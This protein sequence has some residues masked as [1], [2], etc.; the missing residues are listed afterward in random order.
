MEIK[1]ARIIKLKGI[2][3]WA[4]WK[5]QVRITL[6]SNGSWDAILSTLPERVENMIEAVHRQAVAEWRR[7]DIT[8]QRIIATS[9]KEKP[10]LHIIN[11]ESSKAMWDKLMSVYEQK[12]ETSMHML[13]TSN[14]K[15]VS[16]S[17]LWLQRKSKLTNLKIFGE[18]IYF[19]ISMKRRRKWDVKTEKGFF[20]GY[21]EKNKGLSSLAFRA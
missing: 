20:V 12:S 19:H 6:Q 16:P 13:L 14:E 7:K 15:G 10:L 1:I 17:E 8:A 21:D 5:F 11:S 3:N 4:A 18:E 9:V 2:E